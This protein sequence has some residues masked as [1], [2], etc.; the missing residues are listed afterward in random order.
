M[1]LTI[2]AIG[3]TIGAIGVCLAA[4]GLYYTIKYSPLY[5][6]RKKAKAKERYKIPEYIQYRQKTKTLGL[7]RMVLDKSSFKNAMGF[8]DFTMQ[9]GEI[10]ANHYAFVNSCIHN[11]IAPGK[12]LL[13]EGS[14]CWIEKAPSNKFVS[15]KIKTKVIENPSSELTPKRYNKHGSKSLCI[16]S[17]FDYPETYTGPRRKKRLITFYRGIGI[18]RSETTYKSKQK[19]VYLLRKFKV[20]KKSKSWL[21]LDIGNYWVYDVKYSIGP[22]RICIN[23]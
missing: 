18:V 12:I 16:Q 3:I 14:T 5:H 22:N 4:I 10:K 15:Y 13:K 1:Q 2:A 8:A 17:E 11:I 9:D 7:Y 23:E 20:G 6:I 21:P 19:D